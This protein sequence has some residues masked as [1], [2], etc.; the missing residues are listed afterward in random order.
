MT[1]THGVDVIHPQRTW[2][3]PDPREAL[4]SVHP[5]GPVPTLSTS[6]SDTNV[7][8]PAPENA[9]ISSPHLALPLP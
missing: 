5:D 7:M 8:H 2:L 3:L 6:F 1:S 4:G 9:L